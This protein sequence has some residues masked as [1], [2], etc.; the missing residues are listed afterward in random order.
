ML[1]AEQG[2]QTGKDCSTLQVNMTLARCVVA[3]TV[4]TALLLAAVV[5]SGIMG[6]DCQVETWQ[7][8][9]WLTLLPLAL[10]SWL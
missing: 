6:S 8:P 9:C 10:R 7:L 5:G 4:G 2:H 3:E 1:H